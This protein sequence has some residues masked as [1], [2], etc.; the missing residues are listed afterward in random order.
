MGIGRS[1]HYAFPYEEAVSK[2]SREEE[3]RLEASWR[4]WRSPGSELL[5]RR[6]FQEAVLSP[7]VPES[8]AN[9]LFSV[10]VPRGREGLSYRD[11]IIA[12]VV[13]SKS[14]RDERTRFLFHIFSEDGDVVVTARL[15]ERLRSTGEPLSKAL[16]RA[17]ASVDKLTLEEFADWVEEVKA[18]I[19]IASWLLDAPPELTCADPI[20]TFY[21]SLSGVTHLEEQEIVEL[22]KQFWELADPRLRKMDEDRF[23]SLVS[24]PLPAALVPGLFAAF[25]EN[26]DAQIDFKELVC[27]LSASARGPSIERCKF[28]FKIFD[29]DADGILS[30]AE[31]EAMV[32]RLEEVGG[33][34]ASSGLAPAAQAKDILARYAK[35]Q[36]D[37]LTLE[38][39]LLWAKDRPLVGQL[40][41]LLH[42][43]AHVVLGLTPQSKQTEGDI[44][45]SWHR[46]SLNGGQLE[47]GHVWYLIAA[48]WWNQWEHYIFSSTPPLSPASTSAASGDG[49]ERVRGD[50]I[51]EYNG[52][53][54]EVKIVGSPSHQASPSLSSDQSLPPTPPVPRGFR[55]LSSTSGGGGGGSENG[56]GSSSCSSSV[57]GTSPSPSSRAS[58]RRRLSLGAR[59]SWSPCPRLGSISLGGSG[60]SATVIPADAR[61]AAKPGPIDNSPLLDT[62]KAAWSKLHSLSSEGGVLRRA[63]QEIF[64][65][66]RV[67]EALWKALVRWYGGGSTSPPLPRSVILSPEKRLELELHPLILTIV[68]HQTGTVTSSNNYGRPGYTGTTGSAFTHAFSATAAAVHRGIQEVS[69]DWQINAPAPRRV[70]QHRLCVSRIGRVADLSAA[71]RL[72]PESSRLWLLTPGSSRDLDDPER[73]MLLLEEEDLRFVELN[74]TTGSLVLLEVRNKDLTW[75]E[76]MSRLA[77]SLGSGDAGALRAPTTGPTPKGLT[78]LYNLGNTCYMNSAIQCVSNTRPLTLY[79]DKGVHRAELNRDNPL[80]MK[81]HIAL[82]YGDLVRELWSAR[83]K[84]VAPLK[85]KA[86]IGK[87]ASRFDDLQQHDCQELLSFLLDGLHED[88]NRVTR[89]PYV[90]LKDSAGRPD[91]LVAAEAWDNHLKRNRSVVV[92]LFHGL[93]RSQVE[94]GDCGSV[95][96]RFDPFTFLS[97]PLPLD[98][99]LLLSFVLVRLDGSKPTHFGL[100]VPA[101]DS[102]AQLRARIATLAQLQADQLFLLQLTHTGAINKYLAPD[103]KA[104]RLSC[105]QGITLLFAF[106]IPSP[107][108]LSQVPT[109]TTPT[110]NGS[111]ILVQPVVQPVGTGSRE[112]SEDGS[113]KKLPQHSRSISSVSVL[114]R[115]SDV[116]RAPGLEEAIPDL[117]P[118]L[119]FVLGLHRKWEQQDTYFLAHQR[120]RPVVFGLPVVL[121]AETGGLWSRDGLY[122]AVWRQV[123]RLVSP[124]SR[125]TQG[126]PNNHATDGDLDPGSGGGYPFTLA[127]CDSAGLRCARCPWW[128]LCHGCPLPSGEGP[129]E[130]G[131]GVFIAVDWELNAVHLRYQ[132]SQ[133]MAWVEDASVAAAAEAHRS[134]VSLA[135]CLQEFTQEEALGSDNPVY[136]SRCAA[137]CPAKKRLAIWKLPPILIVHFK[138]FQFVGQRWAKSSKM[139]TYPKDSLNMS[140]YVASLG[141]DAL[142][143]VVSEGVEHARLVRPLST[144]PSEDEENGSIGSGAVVVGEARGS[145]DIDLLVEET[146]EERERTEKGEEAE[147]RTRPS[148]MG[149]GVESGSRSPVRKLLSTVKGGKGRVGGVGVADGS[150]RVRERTRTESSSASVA[151]MVNPN[152]HRLLPGADPES[153]DYDLY[154][155]ACHYGVLGAGHYICYAKHPDGSWFLYNDSKTKAVPD[156]DVNGDLAYLLFYQRRGLDAAAYI[157]DDVPLNPPTANGSLPQPHADEHSSD[158]KCTLM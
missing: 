67:P 104:K 135:S 143:G 89:K 42:E 144:L 15:L 56:G 126:L 154:A 1:R 71:L 16:S 45:K 35:R 66:A 40:L 86:T 26:D 102:V 34:E 91:A 13:L 120:A 59:R 54:E 81:G 31:V 111:A 2:L 78:G 125:Q 76:E 52:N 80:G 3:R 138:R 115:G 109:T 133:E 73:E 60:G 17:I 142:E 107:P 43:I 134:P 137:L 22:E 148:Q 58:P 99:C 122:A 37:S 5:G 158:D 33:L 105:V 36:P 82:A 19:P 77:K 6:S 157:P 139:V 14:S 75:P 4:R 147:E 124:P 128:R 18:D 63:I 114:S 127:L 130:L 74:I 146:A 10:F 149:S 28:C 27:G 39:F 24:P 87:Y 90:E 57:A 38:D 123:G 98:D 68:R 25:D 103:E 155:M 88:L 23:R 48:E 72:S 156:E 30:S 32:D 92:E 12:I 151:P 113:E 11:L 117:G 53:G 97:L 47:E 100:R 112:A 110:P 83:S 141:L 119:G 118:A 101:E 62:T 64:D 7:A 145:A 93:L 65:F 51:V 79:F 84:F 85:L 29:R 55:P 108:V 8:V 132:H 95:S 94:C 41:S 50:S 49:G 21:Q 152:D 46:R 131:T 9:Q 61:S 116:G 106:Q 153:L 129:V 136:C 96:T 121:P 44:V 150:D 69:K 140:A 70:P 20:T